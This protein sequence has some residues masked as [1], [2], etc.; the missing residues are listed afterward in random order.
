MSRHQ[1]PAAFQGVTREPHFPDPAC[2]DKLSITLT[3]GSRRRKCTLFFVPVG[4]LLRRSMCWC[5]RPRAFS[6]NDL[7]FPRC[8]PCPCRSGLE[9][10]R[11]KRRIRSATQHTTR[12]SDFKACQ[13]RQ[14][15]RPLAGA[16]FLP[17][18][19]LWTLVSSEQWYTSFNQT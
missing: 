16:R 1:S 17:V 2:L 19:D 13:R 7:S 3:K 11:L 12:L 4:H 18:G 5:C 8:C 10:G 14:I 15:I 9:Q 6:Q